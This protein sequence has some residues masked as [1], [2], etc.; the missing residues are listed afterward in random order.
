MIQGPPRGYQRLFAELKRRRVFRVAAV[1]GAVAFAVMQAADFLVP[2]LHLPEAVATGIALVAILGFPIALVL[3]W[4]LETTPAGVR[5][6]APAEGGELEAIVGQPRVRRWT[7]G[8]LALGGTLLLLGGVWWVMSRG[9][10]VAPAT[11]STRNALAILPFEV[12]GGEALDYLGEGMVDLLATK[13]GGTE[14]LHAIDPRAL[15]AYTSRASDLRGPSLGQEAAR[16]FGAAYFVLGSVVEFSG[17]MQLRASLYS[18]DEPSQPLVEAAAEGGDDELFPMVDA[19]A[20]RLL[21]GLSEGTPG[22]L[23]RLAALTTD[24]ITA[25]KAYLA[26]ERAYREARFVDAVEV[27][28]GALRID[29][30]FA[31]AA[32]RMATAAMWAQN[33]SLLRSAV[34]TAQRHRQALA[35]RERALLEAFAA[36]WAEGDYGRADRLY[37]QILQRYPDEVD[38]WYVLGEIV[39][40]EGV[41]LGYGRAEAREPFE[42]AVALAPDLS[43]ALYHAVNLAGF[44]GDT[45]ALLSYSG[46]LLELSGDSMFALNDRAFMLGDTALQRWMADHLPRVREVVNTY[47]ATNASLYTLESDRRAARRLWEVVTETSSAPAVRALGHVGLA[48]LEMAWGHLA[49]ADRE[50]AE[51]RRLDPSLGWQETVHS[52]VWPLLDRSRAELSALRDSLIDWDPEETEV[53]LPKELERVRFYQEVGSVRSYLIGLLETRLDPAAARKK[54]AALLDQADEDSGSVVRSDLG[55]VLEAE[56]AR[57]DGRP[58]QALR[59]LEEAR[60]WTANP[61]R[62]EIGVLSHYREAFLRAE[63]LYE[64]GRLSEAERWYEIAAE[65][66]ELVEYRG[67][68]LLRLCEI[69]A[70]RGEDERARHA[71]ERLLDLWRDAD[72]ALENSIDEVRSRLARLGE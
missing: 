60:F 41:H 5:R 6:T 39:L 66:W 24:S 35:A 11:E 8:V 3:A 49:G 55:V 22:R 12:R 9:G 21:A 31:L 51:A 56:L 10:D 23:T 30:T 4:A 1:Y 7:A 29:S 45:A 13:L 54:A 26:G 50:L 43:P 53:A 72:P 58:T 47:Y 40:H 19:L 59:R 34:G 46:R 68:A 65:A 15:L 69:R 70:S 36:G 57:L 44:Q 42:R 38:A 18:R 27:F 25:L 61:V 14:E 28:E 64:S 20:A 32:Y 2:A 33:D 48:R 16:R 62:L 17:Q 63:L 37:R 67:P 71:C 52:A